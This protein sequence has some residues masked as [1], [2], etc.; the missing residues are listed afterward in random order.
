MEDITFSYNFKGKEFSV[1][2]DKSLGLDN[3]E[4]YATVGLAEVRIQQGAEGRKEITLKEGEE[5][6]I[7]AEKG[8]E[9]QNRTMVCYKNSILTKQEAE[10]IR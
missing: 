5:I 10:G 7:Q 1:I 9:G 3:E 8:H 2:L 6:K 4:I